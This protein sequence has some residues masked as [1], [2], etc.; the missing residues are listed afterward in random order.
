MDSYSVTDAARRLDC[1]EATIRRQ[2]ET[3][4][5]EAVAGSRPLRIT[6]ESVEVELQAKLDRMGVS[7]QPPA[8]EVDLRVQIA[9]LEGEVAFL[10]G[11]LSDLTAAHSATLDT[12]R[13]I[14]ANSIPNN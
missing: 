3:S 4:A 9:Q 13:R 10:R 12:F 11:A 14:S 5:L 8:S 7:H 6:Y 1:S 2:V